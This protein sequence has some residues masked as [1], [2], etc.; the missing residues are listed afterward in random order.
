MIRKV[1]LKTASDICKRMAYEVSASA[2]IWSAY[3]PK[4]PKCLKKDKEWLELIKGKNCYGKL[5]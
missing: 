2:C 1:L 5:Y 3:Q 4:E